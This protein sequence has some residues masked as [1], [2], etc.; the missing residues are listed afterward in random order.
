MEKTIYDKFSHRYDAIMQGRFVADWWKAFKRLAKKH[1]FEY[2]QVIDLAGGTGEAAGRFLSEGKQVD[3]L[4]QSRAMLAIAEKK[5]PKIS[6]YRQDLLAMKLKRSYD[7]AVCVFGGLHYLKSPKQLEQV[8]RKV[9][10]VL[11]PGGVFCFDQYASRYLK[12]KFGKMAQVMEGDGFFTRW[13]AKWDPRQQATNV[14]I[15]GFD[16]Q[17]DAWQTSWSEQH[18]HYAFSLTTVKQALRSAGYRKSEVFEMKKL[19]KPSQRDDFRIIW[20]QKE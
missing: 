7:L 3:V 11:K 18:R 14:T 9:G 12:E 19:G 8:F 2:I 6:C 15:E 20:A 10:D 13:Q 4:D 17:P 5:F 1:R 16:G